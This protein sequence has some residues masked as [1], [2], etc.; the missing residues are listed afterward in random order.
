MSASILWAVWLVLGLQQ[1]VV[2]NTPPATFVGSWVGTQ[3]WVSENAPPSAK[4]PQQVALVI[5]MVDGKLVGTMPM[6]G[7]ADL[8]AFSD[9]KITGEVLEATAVIRKPTP[10]PNPDGTPRAPQ[11]SWTDDVKVTFHLKADKINLNGTADVMLG[12][13]KWM[14]FKYDLGKKRSLY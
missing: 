5:E 11:R 3:T 10:P 4:A 7:G 12:A 13:V 8:F 2:Q 14:T 6:F 9:S 1:P